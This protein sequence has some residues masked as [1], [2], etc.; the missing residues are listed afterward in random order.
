MRLNF[1]ND[2]FEVR[3]LPAYTTPNPARALVSS[4]APVLTPPTG[5]LVPGA[6]AADQN[7]L[8]ATFF[9]RLGPRVAQ[10]KE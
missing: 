4:R 6:S 3:P 5:M 2:E 9:M 1:S 10:G 8:A 7:L